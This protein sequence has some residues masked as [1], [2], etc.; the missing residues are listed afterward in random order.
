MRYSNDPT[1]SLFHHGSQLNPAQLI[2][3]SQ[4]A[5]HIPLKKQQRI[6]SSRAGNHVSRVKGRGLDY[7]E[8]RQYLPGD[9]I[10][11]MDW[12]VTARTGSPHI[13]VYQ[14][15]KE[16]PVLLVT[17]LRASMNFGSRRTL[18]QLLAADLTAL[19]GWAAIA[20]G[21]RLG[22]LLFNDNDEL[23][24]R[25]KP[26]RRQQ[27]HIINSLAT[28]YDTRPPGS[29]VPASASASPQQRITDMC[30]HLRR[31]A[32]PGSS[33]YFISDW[34][35]MNADA[36]AQLFTLSR[37]CDLTAIQ[38]YDPLEARLPASGW[39]TLTN[40]QRRD[41]INSSSQRQQHSHQQRFEQQQQQLQQHMLR[42]QM[43]LLTLSTADE[44]LPS[45]LAGLGLTRVT[46][47]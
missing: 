47:G 23:D 42:L 30:L 38:I 19:L 26:G 13:K 25:P 24:L 22:A 7:A 33:I 15:E 11:A 20:E 44:P 46:G 27:L 14:E 35:G 16:R 41:L 12:R 45:L 18:K 36:E 8:N 29:H 9:D 21:S 28:L 10:R 17:D 2:R 43:P 40:G 31:I 32:K 39:L 4:L 1:L 34:H 6:L 37:H 3:L 5:R